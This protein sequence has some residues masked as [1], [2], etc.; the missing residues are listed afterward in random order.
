MTAKT[1]DTPSTPQAAVT[2]RST[3]IRALSAATLA[4]A[5]LGLATTTASAGTAPHARAPQTYTAAQLSAA[6]TAATDHA[7]ITVLGKYFAHDPV[8]GIAHAVQKGQTAPRA[9]G[10]SV[11]VSSLNPAFVA[12]Q[13]GAPVAKPSYVATNVVSPTGQTATVQTALA[14]KD[15]QVVNIASGTNE[16]DYTAK[17]HGKGTV[18]REPQINAWYTVRGDRVQPLNTEARAVV[19]PS[20]TSLAAYYRHV[21]S[22]YGHKLPGSSYDKRGEAGGF[23]NAAPN[24]AAARHKSADV[25]AAATTGGI[26]GTGTTLLAVAAAAVLGAAFAVRRRLSSR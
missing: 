26:S 2:R 10:R 20:G 7:T 15:W 24:A 5:A 17:A 14:A 25:T 16:T 23:G 18:F 22:A 21:H 19:G 8:R 11:T 12:G 3:A 4:V 6:R 1:P 9:F 13:T